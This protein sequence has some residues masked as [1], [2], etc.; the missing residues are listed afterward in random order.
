MLYSKNFSRCYSRYVYRLLNKLVK[1]ISLTLF[2]GSSRRSGSATNTLL[3]TH[4]I[5]FYLKEYA[6]ARGL[7]K[8]RFKLLHQ[9]LGNGIPEAVVAAIVTTL[10]C[11][12]LFVVLNRICNTKAFTDSIL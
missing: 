9:L 6:I 2:L 7:Q 1:D 12:T 8:M 10:V 11:K 5:Y 4:L 3:V